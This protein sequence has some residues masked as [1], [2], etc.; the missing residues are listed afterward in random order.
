MK[1]SRPI[2][3]VMLRP[4]FQQALRARAEELGI[5]EAEAVSRLVEQG[6]QPFLEP[7]TELDQARA[8]R[9]LLDVTAELARD[10]VSTMSV[11][12]E[13]LTLAVFERIRL[14]HRPLYELAIQGGYRDAVNRR[15][16]RQIKSAVG[17][18]VLKRGDRPAMARVPRGSEALIGD[19]TLLCAPADWTSSS[20]HLKPDA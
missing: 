20:S 1:K 8:E 4:V 11:W 12:N 6:L 19:F 9:Q 18:Q 16:A 3:Q 5:T 17:A 15:V 14:E 2:I 13:R 10:E 7:G